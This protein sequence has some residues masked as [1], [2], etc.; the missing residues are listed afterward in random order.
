MMMLGK[1]MWKP[2]D[3]ELYEYGLRMM[4][5]THPLET[6]DMVADGLVPPQAIE[7]LRTTNPGMFAKFQQH[8]M[9]N[10]DDIRANSTYDQRV[11][12]GLAVG[13]PVDPTTDPRYVTFMQSM[14]AQTAM[15]KAAGN[16]AE[17]KTPEESMSD[18]QKML[19]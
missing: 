8:V 2:T 18:A 17:S 13:L 5:V 11:A 15:A 3:R 14:H 6:I 1:S 4:G 9:D 19:A 12:L 7:A 10:V 16:A